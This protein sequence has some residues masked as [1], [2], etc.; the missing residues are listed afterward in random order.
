M[1]RV[2]KLAKRVLGELIQDLKDPRVGFTTVT[3]VRITPDLRYARVYVSIL[4]G[5]EQ[6]LETMK[7]LES[8]KKFLRVELGR[9]IRI[10]YTPELIFERDDLPEQAERV[11]TLIRKLHASELP[12]SEEQ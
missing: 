4:G 11:E 7:G 5:E 10:K 3:S 6:Q 12:S 2:Q 1:E 8:A 9:N